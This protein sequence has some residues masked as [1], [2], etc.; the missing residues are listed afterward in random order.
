MTKN[1]VIYLDT[2]RKIK[3][4]ERSIKAKREILAIKDEYLYKLSRFTNYDSI[5]IECHR[6][7][8]DNTRLLYSIGLNE[9]ALERL[10]K[11]VE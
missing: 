6:V 4:L 7:D 5:R 1:N 3:G 9:V 10:R 2:I 8:E 11:E